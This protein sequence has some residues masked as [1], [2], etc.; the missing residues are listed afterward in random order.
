MRS[1]GNGEMPLIGAAIPPRAI[2]GNE[3]CE[4]QSFPSATNLDS[5][6]SIEQLHAPPP[7][8]DPANATAVYGTSVSS[9]E[10]DT[11]S[12][13]IPRSRPASNHIPFPQR[14]TSSE[15]PY[16]DAQT[17]PTPPTSEAPVSFFKHLKAM[18]RAGELRKTPSPAIP[19]LDGGDD[20]GDEHAIWAW[21]ADARSEHSMAPTGKWSVR[22][23]YSSPA[24][25]I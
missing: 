10:E 16:T 7:S 1:R 23:D 9:T 13:V 17:E 12:T 19:R 8:N 20:A 4:S 14:R 15:P 2:G 22:S 24:Y 18:R 11:S 3:D 6:A 21:E 25:A 5:Q